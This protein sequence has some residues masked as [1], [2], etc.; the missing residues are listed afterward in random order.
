VKPGAFAVALLLGS[1]GAAAA[2]GQS[3]FDANCA[4]CHQGG[5]V[6]VPGQFPRL[7]GRAGAIAARPEGKTFLAQVLLNG[8]GGRITVDGEQILGVMPAFD[9]LA[10]AELAAVLTYITGLEHKPV[11]FGAADIRAVRSQ[12]KKSPG[13]MAALHT[14]L[15]A[16]KVI[17]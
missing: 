16:K 8:I 15:A 12:T 4:V 17:P 2:D 5:G 7:A 1:A 14:S 9:S 11:A 6:G 10:D 13:E 3:L